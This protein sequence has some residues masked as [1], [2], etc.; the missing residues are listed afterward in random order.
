VV[1]GTPFLAHY[2]RPDVI[3]LFEI[4][5]NAR[6]DNAYASRADIERLEALL[7]RYDEAFDKPAF[8]AASDDDFARAPW[9]QNRYTEHTQFKSV[10]RGVEFAGRE[11]LDV[12][13][14]TGNG[15]W[16]LLRLGGQVTALEHNPTLIQRGRIVVPEARWIG[17][18]ASALP[19]ESETF[20]I[21]CCNAAL[22]HIRDIPAAVHEM[23]RVLKPGGWFL[24]SGD[25]F[26]PDREGAEHELDVFDKHPAVLLG[27][28]ESI[29]A[30]AELVATFVSHQ[31]SLEVELQAPAV[32]KPGGRLRGLVG[33]LRGQAGW[34]LNELQTLADTGGTVAMRA[35][36]KR[37][38]DLEP[39]TQGATVLRAGDY[40]E[41]L[42]DYETALATLVPLLEDTLMDL[43][44]PGDRQTKFELLNGWQKPRRGRARRTGYRRARWFL[45]RPDRGESLRFSVA[46]MK[47][48]L[49]AKLVVRI[50]GALV[51][52]IP[53][54]SERWAVV[55]VS[56]ADIRPSARFACEIELVLADGG[57]F[58]DYRF[59]VKDRRFV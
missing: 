36:V 41:V 12:G 15:T 54:G 43:P 6:S 7:D 50:D 51:V 30:L 53:P 57:E 32:R 26:R 35:R 13:A 52:T 18:V 9:F 1:Y 10:A 23:L 29:P 34:R 55:H 39:R 5:A 4:A 16:A 8:M 17:G 14:G 21:V 19:F 45:T 38:L 22:H 33:T 31:D 25:P 27:V 3:G 58:E 24:T 20:D 48:G 28:N 49:D 40:A 44:F 47:T 59:A 46:R 11:I 56:L 42:D 37:R 2:E